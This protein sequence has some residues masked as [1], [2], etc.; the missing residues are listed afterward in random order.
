M[1]KRNLIKKIIA[2]APAFVLVPMSTSL[3]AFG[4]Q[5]TVPNGAMNVYSSYDMNSYGIGT[6]RGYMT[7]AVSNDL[8]F[9][10][11]ALAGTV[12]TSTWQKA[13]FVAGAAGSDFSNHLTM[14]ART[15]SL[16][17]TLEGFSYDGTGATDGNFF[18]ASR[19]AGTAYKIVLDAV[20]SARS[21]STTYYAYPNVTESV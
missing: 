11:E 2:G 13:T 18:Y 21:S 1:K 10:A 16:N 12:G 14:T 15:P 3:F 6:V 17:I 19:S 7:M 9:S 20:V 5:I 8:Q 4:D